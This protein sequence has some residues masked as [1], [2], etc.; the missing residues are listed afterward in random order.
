MKKRIIFACTSGIATSTVATEKVLQYCKKIGID[1]EPMQSNVGTIPSQDGM[2]D[3]IVVTSGVKYNLKTPIVNGL[4]LIT[5]IGE[6]ALL[7][8]IADILRGGEID[9]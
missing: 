6:E 8:K 3:L 5:G 4:P 9:G 1:V 2:A 7:K